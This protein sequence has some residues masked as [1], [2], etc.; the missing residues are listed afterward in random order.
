MSRS[1]RLVR[2]RPESRLKTGRGA[3]VTTTIGA[4]MGGYIA[5]R[6]DRGVLYLGG[7]TLTG[8]CALWMAANPHTQATFTAG[9]LAYNC[10]AGVCYAA[11]SALGLQLVGVRNPTAASSS[12]Y[13]PPPPTAPSSM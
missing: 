2:D 13:S 8:L 6:V 1:K 7:G 10:L 5:D 3:A 12:H 4:I 9:V 11:F